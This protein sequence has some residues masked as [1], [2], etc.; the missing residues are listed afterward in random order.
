LLKAEEL[1][2]IKIIRYEE[3]IYY[4]N[5]ENFRYKVIKLSEVDPLDVLNSIQREYKRLLKDFK[6]L[7]KNNKRNTPT[8]VGISKFG[9]KNSIFEFE[10]L[11]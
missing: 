6:K 3:S 1:D 10:I 11:I 5:A 8:E 9:F 4:A 7:K 2:G